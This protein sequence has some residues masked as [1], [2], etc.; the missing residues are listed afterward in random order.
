MIISFY[1]TTLLFS[2]S[3]YFIYEMTRKPDK[4]EIY[5]KT[6]IYFE[7]LK[8]LLTERTF[9]IYN[10][11]KIPTNDGGLKILVGARDSKLESMNCSGRVAKI[12]LWRMQKFRFILEIGW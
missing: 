5:V 4:E 9:G 7:K 2:Q 10:H 8:D 6:A 12:I 1:T 3:I 11:N